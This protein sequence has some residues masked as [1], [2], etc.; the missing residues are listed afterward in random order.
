MLFDQ[1]T[2]P[3]IA[4]LLLAHGAGAGMDSDFMNALTTELNAV[5][6][7][8]VRFEFPY[9]QQRRATGSK[10]PPDRQPKLL[11]CWREVYAEVL[12]SDFLEGPLLIGGKSMG[13]RMA[14]LIAEEL[15]SK[16]LSVKGVCCFGYPFFPKR[17]DGSRDMSRVEHLLNMPVPT[18]IVQGTRDTFG[19][20][21]VIDPLALSRQIRIDWLEDGDHDLNPRVKSG[22]T[23]QQH[24]QAA[25]KSVAEFARQLT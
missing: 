11:E 7:N 15:N 18:L 17:K 5:G 6:V 19:T 1:A 13:G 14:T 21:E 20:P 9:M 8:V 16:E 22:F 2:S 10:R 24:I 4:T 23:Q 12:N 3:A 25:A